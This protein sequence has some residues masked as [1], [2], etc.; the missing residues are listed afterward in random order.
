M[1]P[2]KRFDLIYPIEVRSEMMAKYRKLINH[3]MSVLHS[4]SVFVS[5]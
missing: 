5:F 2:R 3:P 1:R 4:E